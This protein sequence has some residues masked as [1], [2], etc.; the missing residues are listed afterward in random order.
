MV[1]KKNSKV[2]GYFIDFMEGSSIY[3]VRVLLFS[4]YCF[5]MQLK[6]IKNTIYIY[7]QNIKEIINH[8]KHVAVFLT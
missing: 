5:Q 8:I 2:H 1:F 6:D 7:P 4:R 3:T